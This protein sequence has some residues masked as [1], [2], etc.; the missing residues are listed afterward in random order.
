MSE[1]PSTIPHDPVPFM[2]SPVDIATMNRHEIDPQMDAI[3]SIDTTRGNL[4]INQRGFAISPTV[5]DGYIL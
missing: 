5:K 1:Q 3:L 4:I 2:G